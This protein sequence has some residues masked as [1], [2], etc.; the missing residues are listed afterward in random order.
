MKRFS[1]RMLALLMA[2][3][4]AMPVI[5][6]MPFSASAENDV[7]DYL[8]EHLVA[9]YFTDS[10][11]T[12]DKVGNSN[13]TA[14][15]S[16]MNWT[17]DGTYDCVKFPGGN[18]GANTNYFKTSA[19]SMLLGVN[20]TKG[21]SVS[22]TAKRGGNNYQRY[23]E[24]ST[25]EGYG[26]GSK[27]S[28]IYFSC[29][30]NSKI[31]SIP[32]GNS[33]TGSPSISDDGNWHTWTL[34]VNKSRIFVY[35]DEVF[36]GQVQ[37]T[38]RITDAWFNVI[39][40]GNLLLGASSFSGDPLFSGYMRDFKVYNV[41]LTSLQVHQAVSGKPD[42]HNGVNVKYET[43][44][45]FHGT[46]GSDYAITNNNWYYSPTNTNYGLTRY[47]SAHSI[48]TDDSLQY[49]RMWD[50]SDR[51]Y[52]ADNSSRTQGIFQQD[53]DFRF[54]V[55]M[56]SRTD[57]ASAYL[58]GIVDRN[59]NIPIQLLK[60]G[61]VKINNTELTGTNAVYSG[62]NE[63]AHN[64]YTFSFDYSEQMLH[65][66]CYGEW[67]D[68][69]HNFTIQKDYKVTDYGITLNPGD[70]AG[71]N[72][73][74]G[75]GSGHARFGGI[76]F[77][78][79][80][81]PYVPGTLAELKETVALYESKMAQNKIYTNMGTAYEAYV[82]ANRY[83]DAAD[84]GDRTIGESLYRTATDNLLTATRNMEEWSAFIPN[85]HGSFTGDANYVSDADYAQTYKNV[86][87][88]STVTNDANGATVWY[89]N[90]IEIYGGS[91]KCNP[92]L[93][94]PVS[95][96]MYDGV[97]TPNVPIFSFFRHWCSAFH[98]YNIYYYAIFIADNAG[99]MEITN[100]WH[101]N[102]NESFNYQWNYFNNGEVNVDYSDT[103]TMSD[104]K[105]VTF[106]FSSGEWQMAYA[107]I[108]KFTGSMADNEY[109]RTITPT[110]GMNFGNNSSDIKKER[111]VG[112]KSLYVVNYKALKDALG[113][114]IST[115]QNVTSYK[116]GGLTAFFTAYDNATSFNPQTAYDWAS[117][118]ASKV[119]TCGN[120]IRNMVSALDN[121]NKRADIYPILRTEMKTAHSNHPTGNSAETDFATDSAVLKNTYTKSSV[122]TFKTTFSATKTHMANLVENAYQ[123]NSANI[124]QLESAHFLDLKADFSALDAAKDAAIAE[125]DSATIVDAN[126]TSSVA[127]AK[128]YLQNATEFPYEYSADRNDTGVSK[129]SEIAAEKT[130][131]D[132]WKNAV[133]LD[134]RA[135]L[136]KL[137]KAYAKADA[138][139][140]GLNGKAARYD[141]ASV[142]ALIN[143][144]TTAKK[145][146]NI[147][148]QTM[149]KA[150]AATR[151][152]YGQ[153]VQTDANALA[154]DIYA[155]I[156]GLTIVA[157]NVSQVDLSAYEAAVSTI[158]K[159]DP[160][161]YEESTDGSIATAISNA[162]TM[163]ST[164]TETYST[165]TINV[166]DSAVTQ[167]NIEDATTGILTAL[168]KCV[169][170]YDI[171]ANS[172]VTEIG[173][174]NGEYKD[175]KATYGTTMTFKS[176][177]SDTAW[178]MSIKS[179][180]I[181]RT[182]QFQG[183]GSGLETRVMGKTEVKA[184][185]RTTENPCRIRVIRDYDNDDKAPVD[186]VD[187]VSEGREYT[188][189]AAPAV[190]Y[191]T[192]DGYYVDGEK[193]TGNT[194]TVSGDVDVIA[195]YTV[196]NDAS[197]AINATDI[198]GT[199]TSKAAQYNEKVEL[200]GGNGAY[201]WV[202]ATDDTGLHFRPFYIGKNVSM[203]ASEPTELKAV[204]EEQFNAYGF[205]LPA[206]NLRKGGTVKSGEKTI[207]NAQLVAGNADVQEY[208][209]LVGTGNIT[210][211]ML[212]IENSGTHEDYRVLRAKSTRLV[213]A[214]QFSIAIKG[215]PDNYIYRGYVIY[216]D[217]SSLQTEY[218]AIN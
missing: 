162:N 145:T 65:F 144:V 115:A 33:E 89:D 28:Y 209:I 132:G 97:N 60:N 71:I 29:N 90:E 110:W 76:F 68:S 1:K 15:G 52:Y 174:R 216:S 185:K 17:N 166:V 119:A 161:A 120:D 186:L 146:Q 141:K 100:K 54:D 85:A 159:L 143:A 38:N 169:K 136:S 178:Y 25:N 51:L 35:R 117:D 12:Q 74:D 26:D 47:S 140:L 2:A 50:K 156:E 142:E 118:T 39:K 49:F 160:D 157:E 95:V 200:E 32:Y 84:Y 129:N 48:N 45:N 154:D 13:L 93:Y 6:A 30:Q 201:A 139:L 191:Y 102:Q 62:N 203:F 182:M 23:F 106:T 167:G 70:L 150:D 5:L 77:Y 179:G 94:H 127:A 147:T 20:F 63:K 37:D 108:M 36:W 152:N 180:T 53:M 116:E 173:A 34:T 57:S 109:T 18:N 188:L 59:G 208:G 75:K 194:V 148:A 114:A 64:N 81:T 168:T 170:K 123:T 80:Y 46:E 66:S 155:A 212:N 210:E 137:E 206:I 131:F 98:E 16:G 158:N 199:L 43:A 172:G 204:T 88:A 215:L 9:R 217:G 165:A 92:R 198:S 189:E 21:F 138:L 187:F 175:G 72:I 69:S 184:V 134:K 126:T 55:T 195:Y 10:N 192:F 105:K 177:D 121:S 211:D 4:M 22:F 153:A 181:E 124:P 31:K 101:G 213:G 83:I 40:N 111:A 214:N 183:Y 19:S 41:A 56:G 14:V 125:V 24:F 58:I 202:E 67:T 113:R 103:T 27:T 128:A 163:V 107:N 176:G 44:V 197:C 171:V 130:K 42:N 135:D 218:T 164:S 112:T 196:N 7:A 96:M 79:P 133:S 91:E 8:N 149:V 205:T 151:A 3:I 78:V 104:H 61:N 193:V 86:L 82:L 207:F 99:G 122:D 73:L 190:P 87:Y 11:I